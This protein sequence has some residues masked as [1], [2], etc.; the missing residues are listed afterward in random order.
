M[1]R[2]AERTSVGVEH[3]PN[4]GLRNKLGGAIPVVMIIGLVG[5]TSIVTTTTPLLSQVV[6]LV[7]VD[8]NVV[9]KGYRASKLIGSSV[10]NEK[11]EKVGSLDD[12]VIDHD[13]S[14]RLYAVLQVGGFLGL[15]GHLVAVPYD[16]LKFD[17]E[18]R[19]VELPGATK[20]S[21]KNLAEF[22]YRS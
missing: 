16:S 17:D 19:S 15:G 8:V 2:T 10:S 4:R 22:K 12:I 1:G 5:A 21:L 6:A 20:D 7:K 14:A 3:K 13:N 9:A 11:K 18:G